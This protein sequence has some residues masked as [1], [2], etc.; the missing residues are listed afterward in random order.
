[1]AALR[2]CGGPATTSAARRARRRKVWHAAMSATLHCREELLLLRPLPEVRATEARRPLFLNVLIPVTSHCTGPLPSPRDGPECAGGG[3]E[4]NPSAPYD[5]PKSAVGSAEQNPTSPRDVLDLAGGG[6]EQNPTSP[7][8]GAECGEP[9][10]DDLK[11]PAVDV[12]M[13]PAIDIAQLRDKPFAELFG[14]DARKCPLCERPVDD[15]D[16]QDHDSHCEY[17]FHKVLPELKRQHVRKVIVH[18]LV[19]G[20]LPAEILRFQND[21]DEFKGAV[22]HLTDFVKSFAK[23]GPLAH[24]ELLSSLAMEDVMSAIEEARQCTS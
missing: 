24:R 13:E 22:M 15:D 4:Q 18:G 7:R 8:D 21:S 11:E 16:C 20:H 19:H 10:C 9:T 23:N 12:A 1:M 5:G 17:C 3:P 14:P 6:A 2:V